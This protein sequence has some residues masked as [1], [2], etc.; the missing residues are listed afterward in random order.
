MEDSGNSSHQA[1]SGPFPPLNKPIIEE[2]CDLE[3]T[4]PIEDDQVYEALVM[5]GKKKHMGEGSEG[6]LYIF[7]WKRI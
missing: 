2:M 6:N 7:S 5:K 4:G 3:E 1:Y